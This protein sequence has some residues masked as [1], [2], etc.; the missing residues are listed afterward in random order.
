MKT[1]WKFP[2]EVIDFWDVA[3][4]QGAEIICLQM[5]NKKPTIWA[6]V[7]DQAPINW[8]KRSFRT[9]G[10]GHEASSASKKAYVGTYQF[11]VHST[12]FVFHVFEIN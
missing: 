3:M 5:N 4:P 10:T 6:I 11:T 2:L 1:I 8:E 7:E 12:V 9:Y